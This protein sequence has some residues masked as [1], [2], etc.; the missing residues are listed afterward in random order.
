MTSSGAKTRNVSRN[1]RPRGRPE[2]RVLRSSRRNSGVGAAKAA[3]FRVRFAVASGAAQRRDVGEPLRGGGSRSLRRCSSRDR[4][5]TRT[6]VRG[7]VD[8][9]GG[10]AG[11]NTMASTSATDSSTLAANAS[12]ARHGRPA[13]V[14]SRG[15]TVRARGDRARAAASARILCGTDATARCRRANTRP[16]RQADPLI[17]VSFKSL[18]V[19]SGA[20]PGIRAAANDFF[21]LRIA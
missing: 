16:S 14:R 1:R 18:P 19:R 10:S 13:R 3:Q 4:A 2:R 6:T 8:A 12:G 20:R 9:L 17:S 5:A 15:G 7:I 21:N 11:P